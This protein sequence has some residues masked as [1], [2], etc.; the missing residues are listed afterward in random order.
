MDENPYK[1]P[2]YPSSRRPGPRYFLE[3]TKTDAKF[4]TAILPVAVA[5]S[6]YLGHAAPML[7]WTLS[8]IYV[9]GLLLWFRRLP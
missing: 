1:S 4:L 5:L 3:A 7:V 9:G 6:F 8:A 2:M